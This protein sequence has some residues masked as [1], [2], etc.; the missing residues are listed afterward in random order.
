MDIVAEMRGFEIDHEPEGWP[1]VRMRQ[2]SA[3]CDEVERLRAEV[4]E[5][6]ELREKMADI[7]SRTAVALRGPE[8]TLTRWSW[9][10]LPER[11][12]AAIAAIDVMQRAAVIAA[13]DT[14]PNAG[15]EGRREASVPLD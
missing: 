13:T 8:P 15:N 4:A 9:H 12:G 6:D 2:V 14:P 11:A 5:L 3:L 1:A 10:D 7:L